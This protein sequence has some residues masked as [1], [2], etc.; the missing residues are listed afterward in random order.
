MLLGRL[1]T[2]TGRQVV[3]AIQLSFILLAKS[4]L[5]VMV[6][7]VLDAQLHLWS[8]GTIV[9]MVLLIF[10]FVCWSVFEINPNS[11]QNI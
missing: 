8:T 4:Y 5:H 6:L 9:V 7:H 2:Q 10:Q 11:I 1:S 3:F